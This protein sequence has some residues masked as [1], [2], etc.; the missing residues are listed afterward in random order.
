MQSSGLPA[1]RRFKGSPQIRP[2][3]HLMPLI[4]GMDPQRGVDFN[5]PESLNAQ[6]PEAT[7]SQFAC[8][9]GVIEWPTGS[10]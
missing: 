7:H 4:V 9:R 10:A 8:P 3:V 6:S 1:A 5:S 2:K